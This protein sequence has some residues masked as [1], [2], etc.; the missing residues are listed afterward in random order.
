MCLLS[1]GTDASRC[2]VV[3]DGEVFRCSVHEERHVCDDACCLVA[4]VK[5]IDTYVCP[6]SGRCKGRGAR[7]VALSGPGIETTPVAPRSKNNHSLDR[8]KILAVIDATFN[9]S[10]SAEDKDD[11]ASELQRLRVLYAQ[12]ARATVPAHVLGI[13]YHMRSG[14]K[15]GDMQVVP[16]EPRIASLLPP[17][18]KLN[19]DC[20]VMRTTDVGVGDKYVRAVLNAVAVKDSPSA[21][22]A[23]VFRLSLLSKTK[24]RIPPAYA[25]RPFEALKRARKSATDDF[26]LN[27]DR[28]AFTQRAT[29]ATPQIE[30]V[31]AFHVGR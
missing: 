16:C 29:P 7:G 31:R 23:S 20:T 14:F 6:V 9:D 27:V 30:I 21:P 25:F 19:S 22:S 17:F 28:A 13:L 15:F 4:Y 1:D 18:Q 3:L 8:D 5:P 11:M 12:H 10:L 2:A 24:A 26:A